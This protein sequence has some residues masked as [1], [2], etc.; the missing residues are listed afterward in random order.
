[1]QGSDAWHLAEIVNFVPVLILL[2]VFFLIIG[3]FLHLLSFHLAPS[4]IFLVVSGSSV[5]IYIA[6]LFISIVDCRSP[7]RSAASR[8]GYYIIARMRSQLLSRPKH[9]TK[10]D[11]SG[12]VRLSEKREQRYVNTGHVILAA[13]KRLSDLSQVTPQNWHRFYSIAQ[14]LLARRIELDGNWRSFMQ[15]EG[16]S[17]F[18]AKVDS[19]S[20]DQEGRGLLFMAAEKAD[21]GLLEVLQD[22]PDIGSRDKS[23]WTPLHVAAHRNFDIT[24]MLQHMKGLDVE[25]KDKNGQTP[26]SLAASMGHIKVIK[27]LLERRDVDLNY[28]G[29]GNG[30][31][32]LAL[33]AM[34]SHD[35]VVQAL[36]DRDDIE[37]N[38]K[39][40]I[41]GQ[42]PLS[43]AAAAGHTAVVLA[44]L[45]QKDINANSKDRNDRTPLSLAAMEGHEAVVQLLMARADIDLNVQ[46]APGGQT[47]LSLSAAAGHGAVVRLLLSHKRIDVNARDGTGRTPL[48]WAA[49]NGH[50]R[51]ARL[52]LACEDVNADIEDDDGRTA[53]SWAA[54]SGHDIITTM[55]LERKRGPS[56]VPRSHETQNLLMFAAKGDIKN[57]EILLAQENI[58]ADIKDD[59]GRTPLHWAAQSGYSAVVQLLLSRDDVDVN[60][61]DNKGSTALSLAAEKGHKEVVGILLAQ[62]NLHADPKDI[63]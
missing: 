38:T 58:N 56:S 37:L 8:L 19:G 5:V 57:V 43:L 48:S 50:K 12:F 3:L 20:T 16:S 51:A 41:D 54:L 4:W 31:T 14:E 27:N 30:R 53:L 23:G 36:L 60:A 63:E 40:D 17:A 39:D 10:E 21:E 55:I 59:V 61:K 32:P 44:L 6:T 28:R 35:A 47:P 52:L 13:V 33:A 46:D 9:F 29:S 2:S 11:Y 15:Q 42:T 7:F 25:A 18:L 34:S 1:M 45:S 24:W 62:N 26:L 49:Q 22:V